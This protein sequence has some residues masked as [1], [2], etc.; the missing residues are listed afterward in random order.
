MKTKT[1]IF[2]EL[3]IEAR[4]RFTNQLANIT[5]ADLEKKLLPSQ[6]SIGFLMRHIGDVELLFAKNVFGDSTVKVTAKTVIDKYDTGE[7]T[8]LEEL[9]AYVSK[10]F[11]TLQTIVEKQKDEDWETVITTKE[12]GA[13]TKA[14]AFGRI[15]SHTAYHAGQLALIQKYC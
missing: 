12:F 6:N 14:E 15:V 7:W 3:W 2:L 11:E 13:K 1:D 5:A 4:T 8:N 10:S 9:K